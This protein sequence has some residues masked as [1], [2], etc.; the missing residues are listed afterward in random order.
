MSVKFTVNFAQRASF[1]GRPAPIRAVLGLRP[2]RHL[3]RSILSARLLVLSAL[4]FYRGGPWDRTHPGG[5][6]GSKGMATLIRGWPSFWGEK[7]CRRNTECAATPVTPAAMIA[8]ATIVRCARNAPSA[9]RA[10]ARAE[11][12]RLPSASR[13]LPTDPLEPGGRSRR[14]SSLLAGKR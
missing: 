6:A 5:A 13:F 7:K 3:G 8:G 11:R 2:V 10:V 4:L 14:T 1:M 12:R 9:V